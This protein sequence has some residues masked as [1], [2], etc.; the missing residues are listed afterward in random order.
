[1]RYRKGT[2]QLEGF[3]F[4]DIIAKLCV[5]MPFSWTAPAA[6]T[7]ATHDASLA[8]DGVAGMRRVDPASAYSSGAGSSVRSAFYSG[9]SHWKLPRSSLWHVQSLFLLAV[10]F[11]STGLLRLCL[12]S[13]QSI[14]RRM[15]E[16]WR[17]YKFRIVR[18]TSSVSSAD[19]CV[20]SLLTCDLTCAIFICATIQ[21]VFFFGRQFVLL[22]T[23]T[24]A[25]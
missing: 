14:R 23:I 21:C 10:V 18:E 16:W 12:T 13:P 3:V 19:T 2:R 24:N 9:G 8:A 15:N 25:G 17:L 22:Y 5:F 1:M 20:A 7:A 11:L 6:P 4:V